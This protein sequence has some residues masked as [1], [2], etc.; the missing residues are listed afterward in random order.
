MVLK[1]HLSTG[2]HQALKK[3]VEK[4]KLLL[5]KLPDRQQV[6]KSFWAIFFRD[7]TRPSRRENR[8]RHRKINSRIHGS[9]LREF[10]DTCDW[11]ALP[12]AIVLLLAIILCQWSGNWKLF[13]LIWVEEISRK[14]KNFDSIFSDVCLKGGKH[15]LC[16]SLKMNLLDWSRF[17]CKKG[18]EIEFCKKLEFDSVATDTGKIK[19]RLKKK[20]RK[21]TYNNLPSL[22]KEILSTHLFSFWNLK[23]KIFGD[24][25]A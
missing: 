20:D 3:E 9:R 11:N 12:P 18:F 24:V 23:E 17:G 4:L 22:F 1:T 21:W 15:P 5:A 2:R 7:I 10:E 14:E 16:L 8:N 13:L 25:L 19:E 6:K